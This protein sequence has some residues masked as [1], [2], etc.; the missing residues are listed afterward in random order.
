MFK[1]GA[2]RLGH[3]EAQES[4]KAPPRGFLVSENCRGSGEV[5]DSSVEVSASCTGSAS[6]AAFENLSPVLGWSVCGSCDVPAMFLR[7]NAHSGSC[8][9]LITQ[10]P[11]RRPSLTL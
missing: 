6:D 2:P 11:V 1:W 7:W 9:G 10:A 8:E 4:H 5:G 3:R